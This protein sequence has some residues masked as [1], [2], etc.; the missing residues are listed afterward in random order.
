MLEKEQH[1]Y[2]VL[3]SKIYGTRMWKHNKL[4]KHSDWFISADVMFLVMFVKKNG[5]AV[6]RGLE[7]MSTHPRACLSSPPVLGRT[8]CFSLD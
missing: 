8:N 3:N 1:T 4:C 7:L 6:A 2:T 5:G